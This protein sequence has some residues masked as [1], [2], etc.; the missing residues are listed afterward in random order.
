MQ[1]KELAALLD[2]SP[3]MV[4]RLA[5]RGMPTDTLERAQRWRRR[6][7]EPGRVKGNR[8]GTGPARAPSRAPQPRPAPARPVAVVTVAS[9]EAASDLL[10]GALNR[11]D[12]DAKDFRLQRLRELLAQSEPG[13]APRLSL[14]VWVALLGYVMRD[15]S[16]LWTAPDQGRYLTPGE[17]G[18]RVCP[19][20]PWPASVTM[21]D[22]CDFD[23]NSIFG[24]P[25]GD[26]ADD[27]EPE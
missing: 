11:G 25:D 20:N 15:E 21:F 3:A 23:G 4:S 8:A 14:R 27:D 24:W 5:R 19:A 6:H 1:Q 26:G 2:I 12:Q 9:L 7:L 22:A 17:F 10:D 18:Q 16:D 13:A